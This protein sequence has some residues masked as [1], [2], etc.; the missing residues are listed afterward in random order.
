MEQIASQSSLIR[1]AWE[2]H[3]GDMPAAIDALALRITT[4]AELRATLMAPIIRAWCRDQISAYVGSLRVAAVETTRESQRGERLRSVIGMT[5]FDFPLPG[6][7]RLGDANA[8]EIAEGAQAY[9]ETAAD[10]AHKSRWLQAVAAKVG[11]R[12]RCEEALTLA[13]LEALMEA[14]KV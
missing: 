8:A 6:G 4:D 2:A 9:A 5:L 11:K 7:K 12:N 3:E 13:Q 10:A 14:A 1:N